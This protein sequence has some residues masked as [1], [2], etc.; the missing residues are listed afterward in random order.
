MLNFWFC[1]ED[2]NMNSAAQNMN[3][4]RDKTTSSQM[5][6]VYNVM[7]MYE[8]SQICH[9]CLNG[10]KLSMAIHITFYEWNSRTWKRF[11]PVKLPAY[12]KLELF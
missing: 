7:P 10:C 1:T 9:S 6:G 8:N 12:R 3:H 11:S 5:G 2:Q 4:A